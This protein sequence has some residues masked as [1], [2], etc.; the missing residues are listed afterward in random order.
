MAVMSA[1]RARG[2]PSPEL[3]LAAVMR[4]LGDPVR[5]EIVRLLTDG[6]LRTSGQ[7][8]EHVN[9][10][11]STCSY[12]LKQLVTAGITECWSERTA[13]YPVLRRKALDDRFPGL[14]TAVLAD[15]QPTAHP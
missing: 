5:L 6:R 3:D 14:F 8:A 11:A 7:I 9:L 13:R 15:Y 1:K 10:P 2:N 12:H 4:A